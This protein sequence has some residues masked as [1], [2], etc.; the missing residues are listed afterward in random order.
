MKSIRDIAW[1][2]S[3]EEYRADTAISYSTLS[4]FEREGW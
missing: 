3:E 4:R 1:N 2:V